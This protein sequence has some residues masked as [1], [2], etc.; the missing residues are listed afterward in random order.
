MLFRSGGAGGEHK[1]SRGF[2]PVVTRSAHWVFHPGLARA[3][4]DFV[5]RERSAIA[6]E[7]PRITAEAGMKPF[8]SEE[9]G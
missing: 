1:L 2:E 8:T 6:D 7:L 3:I 9:R 5:T 4:D